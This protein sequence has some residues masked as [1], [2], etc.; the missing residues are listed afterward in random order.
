MVGVL[1]VFYPQK[2]PERIMANLFWVILCV[3]KFYVSLA[4]NIKL[5]QI[6]Y[7]VFRW[8]RQRVR[9]PKKIG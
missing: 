8:R 1:R 6:N 7:A 2:N 3:G 5:W 4:K 9:P